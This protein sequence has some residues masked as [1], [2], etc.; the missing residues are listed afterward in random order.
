M[1][2]VVVAR[3]HRCVSIEFTIRL[4]TPAD[5]PII[6]WHR[7]RMWQD[8]GDLP[9][10]LFET[11]RARA[12]SFFRAAI[13]SRDYVGWVAAPAT[14]AE[15]IIAGAG[16]SLRDSLPSPRKMNGKTVGVT[17]GKLGLL[18]NVFTEPEWRRRGVAMLLMQRVIDWS[19]EQRL[20][21]LILHASDAGRPLYEKMGFRATNEMRLEN[22]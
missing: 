22:L 2:P 19:H 18:I 14:D 6:A 13:I 7:A 16:V 8:M 21:R 10:E 11:L 4:A 5:A 1:T 3:E 20:D 12:E 17:T 9:D 15:T